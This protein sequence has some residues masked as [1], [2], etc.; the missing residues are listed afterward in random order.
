MTTIA[1]ETTHS[2]V[3]AVPPDF[4]WNHM[5]N[6]ANWDDPP[7]TFDIVGPFAEGSCGTTHIPGQ[8]V[9]HWY[10]SEVNSPYSY[11]IQ[12]SLEGAVLSFAWRFER[13]RQGRTKLTQHI[14]LK[15]DNAAAYSTQVEQAFAAGLAAGMEKVAKGMEQ[16]AGLK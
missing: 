13:I 1:W 12:T 11:I 10:V 7:A 6:V 3:A 9:R 16:A 4:A 2:V 8:E 15:G 5:T 14:V